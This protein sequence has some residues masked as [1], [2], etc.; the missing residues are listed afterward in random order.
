MA[1][2]ESLDEFSERMRKQDAA[3][4]A[5]QDAMFG[6][7][8]YGNSSNND[9]FGGNSG[10][11]QREKIKKM[12]RGNDDAHNGGTEITEDMINDI[13]NG[14]PKDG[15]SSQFLGIAI[16]ILKKHKNA[17]V[18]G[19]T[20]KKLAGNPSQEIAD[21]ISKIKRVT[22]NGN[23]VNAS[24]SGPISYSLALGSVTITES[25]NIQINT[26]TNS[27]IELS[28]TGINTSFGKLSRIEITPNDVKVKVGWFWKTV[29]E[30]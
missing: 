30:Y 28:V 17:F 22:K 29:A 24:L 19:A 20:I 25:N 7:S 12:E 15:S 10:G 18:T 26:L 16:D 9:N 3:V 13:I 21:L 1:D 27:L 5:Q 8:G 2:N 6:R 14:L 4:Q 23:N 11:E